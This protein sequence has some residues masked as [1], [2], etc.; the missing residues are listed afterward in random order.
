MNDNRLVEQFHNAI[1]NTSV[2]VATIEACEPVLDWL[3]SSLSKEQLPNIVVENDTVT[4]VFSSDPVSIK[5]MLVSNIL[6]NGHM[7]TMHGKGSTSE[8]TYTPKDNTSSI[9][10]NI[11]EEENSRLKPPHDVIEHMNKII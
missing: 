4:L 3:E 1:E 2:S 5:N 10:S 9:P 11:F 8:Y 7:V 6:I